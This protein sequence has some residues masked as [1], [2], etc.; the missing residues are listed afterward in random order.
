M[1]AYYS[2]TKISIVLCTTH[3]SKFIFKN[4]RSLDAVNDRSIDII[5]STPLVIANTIVFMLKS[6]MPKENRTDS[7]QR[8]KLIALAFHSIHVVRLYI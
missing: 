2:V 1:K 7:N 8:Q 4:D 3:I 5:R 6:I